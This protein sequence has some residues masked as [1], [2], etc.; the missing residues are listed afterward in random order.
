MRSLGRVLAQYPWCRHRKG[1]FG[2]GH[3]CREKARESL[4]LCS[5]ESRAY[6]SQEKRVEQT[7]P[8]TLGEP[9]HVQTPASRLGTV[10]SVC[11]PRALCWSALAAL[12]DHHVQL[13]NCE[14][15]LLF[16]GHTE[17]PEL[18]LCQGSGCSGFA[19][20]PGLLG[21]G[22][23]CCLVAK[24]CLNLCD[25]M[26]CSPAGSSVHGILQ[27][28]ILEWVARPSS[29]GSSQPKDRFCLSCTA[30]RLFTTEPPGDPRRDLGGFNLRGLR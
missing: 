9:G 15:C 16:S 28:R 7:L 27:A 6:R 10:T 4:E 24:L 12:G 13:P 5:P 30:G 29:R 1:P 22:W 18:R 11:Q 14:D 21:L 26:D 19:V 3:E 2:R 23:W 8:S 17:T 20:E 25:P